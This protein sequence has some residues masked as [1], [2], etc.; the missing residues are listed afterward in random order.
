MIKMMSA[1]LLAVLLLAAPAM[2]AGTVR[3]HSATALDANAKMMHAKPHARMHVRHKAVK[4][5]V[6]I[7]RPHHKRLRHHSLRQHH[8]IHVS[9][10]MIKHVTRGPKRG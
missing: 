1:A 8:Q 9:K 6:R 10:A 3:D 2:A 7:V 4:S 5:H